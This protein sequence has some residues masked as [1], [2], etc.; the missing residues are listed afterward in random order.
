MSI[1]SNATKRL[2]RSPVRNERGDA[3]GEHE[4]RRLE[5]DVV[6][7]GAR[8][9]DGVDEHGEQRDLGDDEEHGGEPVGDEGDAHRRRPAAGF[10]HERAVAVD[11]DQQD[12][13]RRRRASART[14]DADDP[15]REPRAADEDRQR[16]AD[17]RQHD[18]ERAR[19][20]SRRRPRRAMTCLLVGDLVVH[21]VGAGDGAVADVVLHL[22][23]AGEQPAAVG[24]REQQR[25]DAE[26][27]DDRGERERLR[28]RVGEA[29]RRRR[30]PMIG[31]S[32]RRPAVMSSTLAPWVS[33]PR[34]MM[35]RLSLRC[36]SR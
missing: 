26:G 9:A 29:R 31:G 3:G 11:L 25:G 1:I 32:P 2:N 23:V 4:V 13:R 12:D 20:R 7:L 18:R 28:E 8:L 27:D 24:E 19:A 22:V 36:S 17:E 5:A 14:V 15:L 21:D 16:R 35:M 10:G 34:P 33:R 30:S 6:A